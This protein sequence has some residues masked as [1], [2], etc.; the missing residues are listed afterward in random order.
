VAAGIGLAAKTVGEIRD[1]YRQGG[2]ERALYDKPRPGAVPKLDATSDS[3]GSP[4]CAVNRQPVM[5][6]GACG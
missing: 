5:R 3:G 2:W 1:R 6:A 4:W